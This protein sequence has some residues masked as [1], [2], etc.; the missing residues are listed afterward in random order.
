MALVGCALVAAGCQDIVLADRQIEIDTSGVVHGSVYLDANGSGTADQGDRGADGLRLKLLPSTGGG[1]VASATTDTAGLF[2]FDSV[3]VGTFHLVLDSTTLGDSLEVVGFDA[4][5]FTIGAADTA[6]FNFHVTYPTYDLA[7]VRK[8][9][10]GRKVFT[11]GIALNPRDALGDAAVHL[12]EGNTYLR[13][14]DVPRVQILPGDSVRFL[15]TTSERAGQPILSDVTAFIVKDLAVLPRPVDVTSGEAA[16]A[17]DGELDAAL[18]RVR[19]ADILDTATVENDF[20]ATVDDGS[21]PVDVVVRSF[22]SINT[23]PIDP[24]SVRVNSTT[25]ILVPVREANGS[26]RWRIEPRFVSDL[27]LE[28]IPPDTTS[29]ASPSAS[30]PTV[31]REGADRAGLSRGAPVP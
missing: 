31:L 22:L 17:R 23:S 7:E 14:T 25:G 15:G 10:V 5:T 11:H 3:P 6:T 13:A 16:S 1:D 26:V 8:L 19:D 2:S 21:G 28:L 29:T 27:K 12:Q 9:P 20:V 18:V 4:D 24:D 30:G